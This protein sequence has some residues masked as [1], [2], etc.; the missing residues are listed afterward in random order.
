MFDEMAVICQSL[1]RLTSFF[2][3]NTEASTMTYYH[4]RGL[5][6]TA[7][8]SKCL[9]QKKLK[10]GAGQIVPN[11]TNS[12][13][14]EDH[15]KQSGFGDWLALRDLQ[16]WNQIRSRNG[17]LSAQEFLNHGRGDLVAGLGRDF[18]SLIGG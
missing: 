7:C 16:N 13:I 14:I 18:P 2:E 3:L 15:Y 6:T 8:S 4:L 11:P 10:S 5:L 12:P 9:K 17:Q 1:D